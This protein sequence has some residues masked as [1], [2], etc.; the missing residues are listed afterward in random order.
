M[1]WLYSV[2]GDKQQYAIVSN[3]VFTLALYS[4]CFSCLVKT[5]TFLFDLSGQQKSGGGKFR[6]I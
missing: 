4:P 2:R 1:G 5:F 6:L 3:F